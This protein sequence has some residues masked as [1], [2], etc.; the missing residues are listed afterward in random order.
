VR[1][2]TVS[3]TAAAR[4]ALPEVSLSGVVVSSL[5]ASAVS[6]SAIRLSWQLLQ[7]RRHVIEGFRIRYRS[8]DDASADDV[9]DY[10]TKTVRPGDVTQFLLTGE[11]PVIPSSFLHVTFM[12]A[13]NQRSYSY[14]KCIVHTL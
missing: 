5:S 6:S 2:S 11:L 10:L 7:P 12:A 4:V 3:T 1:H 8:L 14:I 13:V 9:V